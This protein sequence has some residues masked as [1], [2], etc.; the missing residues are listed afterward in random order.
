MPDAPLARP[1]APGV[2]GHTELANAAEL[3]KALG[4]AVRLAIVVELAKAPRSAQELAGVLGVRQPLVSGIPAPADA[5]VARLVAA[6]RRDRRRV[7]RLADEQVRH[8]VADAL[9]YSLD[10]RT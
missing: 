6:E 4:A 7:Y 5:S 1:V 3:F 2:S 10:H 9:R 8:I